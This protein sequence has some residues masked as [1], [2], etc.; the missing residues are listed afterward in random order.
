META[1]KKSI[2]DVYVCHGVPHWTGK[3]EDVKLVKAEIVG[4]MQI[5]MNRLTCPVQALPNQGAEA[6]EQPL[7][8]EQNI[9]KENGSERIVWTVDH[10]AG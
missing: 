8:A 9:L 5:F 3:L 6:Y 7:T 1:L 10:P 2:I 4:P